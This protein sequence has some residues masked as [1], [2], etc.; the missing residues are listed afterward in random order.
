MNVSGDPPVCTEPGKTVCK[1]LAPEFG[2]FSCSCA[3]GYTDN[4][5][6]CD[7]KQSCFFTD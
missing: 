4:D 2:G 3:D 5:G 6:S 1:D 7:G